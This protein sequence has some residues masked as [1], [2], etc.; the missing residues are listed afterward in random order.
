MTEEERDDRRRRRTIIMLLPLFILAAAGCVFLLFANVSLGEAQS[1]IPAPLGSDALANYGKDNLPGRLR[2]LSISIVEAVIR[3]RD[4]EGEDADARATEVSESLKSPVPT[5]TPKP[6]DPT[7]T[8]TSIPTTTAT[9]IPLATGTT[10]ATGSP[11]PSPVSSGT[12]T[13]T[14]T[15]APTSTPGPTST[16]TPC[17]PVITIVAPVDGATYTLAGE[18]PGQAIAYD[19]DC[20]SGTPAPDGTGIIKV[21]FELKS[22][23][24][25]W[26]VVHYEDQF[27]VKY[28]AFEGTPICNT[29]DL[30]AGQWP[31]L[32]GSPTPTPETIELGPHKLYA[33]AQDDEGN[34]SAWVHVDFIIDPAPTSTPTPTLTPSPTATNTPTPIPPTL[35]PTPVPPTLTPSPLPPTPTFTPDV[36]S[37]ISIDTFVSGGGIYV[38]WNINNSGSAVSLTNLTITWPTPNGKLKKVKLGGATIWTGDD[39]APSANLNLSGTVPAGPPTELRTE[40]ENSAAGSGY[41]GSVT[42]GTCAPFTISG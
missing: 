6:G 14:K 13:A 23:A 22:E 12:P 8:P 26:S 4:P 29:F 31:S 9:S 37:L 30:N 3:D 15:D 19:P 20:S 41:S 17:G 7:G 10:T 1:F 38:T 18:L 27:A 33:R 28:C 5:V 21:E 25:G 40:F 24:S 42:L 36:C 34:W 32:P 39:D 2:S 35:T 16:P 11:S